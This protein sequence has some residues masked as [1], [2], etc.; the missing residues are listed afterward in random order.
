MDLLTIVLA[1]EATL[2]V[3]SV[4]LLLAII[5]LR[6]KTDR[7]IRLES[8]FRSRAEPLLKSFM[9]GEVPVDVAAAVLGK[10]PRLARQLLMEEAD[11]LGDGGREKLAPLTRTFP[12]VEKE[13]SYLRSRSWEKRLRAVEALGYL[14]NDDALPGLMTALRDEVLAVRFAAAQSLARL[15]CQDAAQPILR[16]LDVPGEVSQ[17]RVVEVLM[18]LGS[19]VADPMIALL[20]HPTIN[21]TSLAIAARVVGSLRIHRA[22]QPLEG[23]LGQSSPNVRLNAVRSIAAI[24]PHGDHAIV[25]SIAALG[26]DPSWEVRNAVMQALGKMG[27]VEHST[28]LLQGLSDPEWWV[29]H[30]AAEAL[31]EL[32]EPG[33]TALRNA[34]EN[35]VDGY[36]RDMSRQILQQHDIP[37][38]HTEGHP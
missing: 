37:Q 6:L 19:R 25:G 26:E 17:R 30:S 8:E 18:I 7:N 14:G 23:L 35:H 16:A 12:F 29:R 33:I 21:E 9:V 32:G 10:S 4:I 3:L 1:T 34:A 22:L 2:T 11:S 13:L 15:G 5:G 38:P 28:L 27:A 20:S 36:G 24:A 31:H